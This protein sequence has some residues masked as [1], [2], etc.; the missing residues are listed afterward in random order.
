MRD[1]RGIDM[2]RASKSWVGVTLIVAIAALMLVAYVPAPAAHR[3]ADSARA[4]PR[5]ETTTI[6]TTCT[7][8]AL[9]SAVASGGVVDY[10]ANC[11]SVAFSTPIAV[12]TTTVDI[13]SN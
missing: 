10:G 8:S 2:V 9:A 11:T 4:S 13:E 7:E 12:G 5:T 3:D 6:V 1:R